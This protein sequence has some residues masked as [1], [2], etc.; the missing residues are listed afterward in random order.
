MYALLALT[1][2]TLLLHT[3]NLR[4]FW[5]LI[6]ID[7]LLTT[8]RECMSDEKAAILPILSVNCLGAV[9]S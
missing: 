9:T 4:G 1:G 3:F 2:S 7:A 6:S 8:E 5:E